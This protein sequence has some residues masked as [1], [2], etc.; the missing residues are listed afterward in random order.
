MVMSSC[1]HHAF[2]KNYGS[3]SNTEKWE[4]SESK[5]GREEWRKGIKKG[6]KIIANNKK[7]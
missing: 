7:H 1:Q 6:R 3:D 4:E 2:C 5:E